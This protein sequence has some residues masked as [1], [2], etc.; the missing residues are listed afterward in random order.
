MLLDLLSSSNIVSFNIKVADLIG[1]EGAVYLSELMSINEKALRKNKTIDGDFFYIDRDY[2][3][4]RTTLTPAKQKKIEE[5]LCILEILNQ[6]K[7]QEDT[8]RIDVELLASILDSEID[9]E[10]RIKIK[11]IAKKKSPEDKQLGYKINAKNNVQTTIPPLRTLFY[12]WI[13]AVFDR[14]KYLSSMAV[15]ENEKKLYEATSD[16]EAQ[17]AI[18]T[19]AACTGYADLKW[20]IEDY[21]KKNPSAKPPQPYIRRQSNFSGEVF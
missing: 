4:S 2:I 17:K 7:N 11:K 1:L 14:G 20:A 21:F 12:N 15:Q 5:K 16:L 19:Q 10:T 9:E 6:N 18:M 8:F 13:D 3:Q